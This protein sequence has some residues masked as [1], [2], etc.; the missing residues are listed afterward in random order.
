MR[1]IEEL[2]IINNSGINLFNFCKKNTKNPLL[3]SGFISAFQNF[4]ESLGYKKIES[5]RLGDSKIMIYR[6]DSDIYYVT[7]SKK[8]IKDED[9][10]KYLKLVEKKFLE[11][12]LDE[13]KSFTGD[14]NIFDDFGEVITDL[15]GIKGRSFKDLPVL[16]KKL[17]EQKISFE[18]GQILK[19]CDGKHT[20]E[21]ICYE[22]DYNK[23]K[24]KEVIRE[25][26]RKKWIEIK[27]VLE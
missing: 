6:G 11:N 21:E 1:D 14:T 17:S 4:M 27:R 26:Q 5:I 12:Y 8:D 20:I 10:I 15:L 2:W 23:L 25:Y 18:A 3:F 22:T 13:L 9:I 24:V 19:F 16:N 7:R